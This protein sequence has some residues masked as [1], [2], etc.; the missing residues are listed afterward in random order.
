MQ[1]GQGD[2]RSWERVPGGHAPV[3]LKPRGG[4]QSTGQLADI[5][6]GGA[7]FVCGLVLAPGS[8]ID[9]ELPAANGAVAARVARVGAN[10]LAVAFR[11]DPTTLAQIDRVLAFVKAAGSP[12]AMEFRAAS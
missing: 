9:V 7:S 8:E 6:R 1:S 4:A 5:S 2:L 3:L 12:G 11:Q 10:V